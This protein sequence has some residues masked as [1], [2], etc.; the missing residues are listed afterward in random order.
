MGA[1]EP[2]ARSTVLLADDDEAITDQLAPLLERSGFTVQIVHDGVQAL[3][4]ARSD[5]VDL[6]VLDILM[7]GMDGREVLRG[8]R[9]SGR[10]TPVVLLTRVGES[11][12]RTMALEEGADDYLNKPFDPYELVAR[13]RAIQR[14]ATRGLPPLASAQRLRAGRL[15]LDR[16]SRRAWLDDRELLVTPKASLLLEYLMTHPDELLSR[17]RLLEALW[18]WDFPAGTRAVDNRVAELRKVL[19]DDAGRPRWIQ[20]VSGQ[21]YRFVPDVEGS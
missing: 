19:G 5:T 14:R 8:I 15:S 9:R 4:R 12:E 3:A 13:L 20:T 11:R 21:G 16:A 2:T 7:P 6:V 10:W 17:E 18:G 1:A